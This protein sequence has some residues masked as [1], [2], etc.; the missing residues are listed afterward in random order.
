MKSGHARGYEGRHDF[1][2]SAAK[3]NLI[4]RPRPPLITFYNRTD[5]QFR[6]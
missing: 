1:S 5:G 6:G 3:P 4:C 2:G